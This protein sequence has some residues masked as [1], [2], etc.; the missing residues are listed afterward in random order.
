MGGEPAGVHG[1]LWDL[2]QDQELLLRGGEGLGGYGRGA[3][4]E[5]VDSLVPAAPG[6]SAAQFGMLQERAHSA[7]T[8]AMQLQEEVRTVHLWVP[9]TD[10]FAQTECTLY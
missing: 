2:L 1:H 6:V 5:S 8:C 4:A 7:A 3:V 10:I 9:G